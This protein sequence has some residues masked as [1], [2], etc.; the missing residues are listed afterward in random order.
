VL[1]TPQVPYWRAGKW[2]KNVFLLTYDSLVSVRGK[3]RGCVRKR[4][5][6]ARKPLY[7]IG[8]VSSRSKGPPITPSAAQQKGVGKEIG[9]KGQVESW[10]GTRKLQFTSFYLFIYFRYCMHST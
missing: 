10:R 4:L 2:V 8:L 3:T 7:R 6:Q 5:N 9:S 1:G